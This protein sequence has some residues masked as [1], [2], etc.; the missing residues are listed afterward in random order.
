MGLHGEAMGKSTSC[1]Y[2]VRRQGKSMAAIKK[3]IKDLRMAIY[4][5]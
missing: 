1:G 4:Q 2:R 5:D 3:M